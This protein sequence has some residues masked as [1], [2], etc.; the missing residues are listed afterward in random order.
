LF[1][2][3]ERFAVVRETAAASE[4]HGAPLTPAEALERMAQPNRVYLIIHKDRVPFWQA[5][6]T[7]RYH[8]YHQ[9]TTCGA[10][11]VVNNHP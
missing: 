9:V 3:D 4:P 8:I 5:Q 1:Y 7:E 10:H 2:L 11:A 6:L